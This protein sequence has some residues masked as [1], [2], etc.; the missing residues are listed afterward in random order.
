LKVFVLD[1]LDLFTAL[2]RVE[3][4]NHI[5]DHPEV[6]QAINAHPA[7]F[8]C[9][10]S[11]GLLRAAP[12]SQA[13]LRKIIFRFCMIKSDAQT[14]ILKQQLDA[15][16]MIRQLYLNC[17]STDWTRLRFPT[18]LTFIGIVKTLDDMDSFWEFVSIHPAVQMVSVRE[19]IRSLKSTNSYWLL[20]KL[21]P[22]A[23]RVLEEGLSCFISSIAIKKEKGTWWLKNVEI[24]VECG[25]GLVEGFCSKV[26]QLGSVFNGL[27]SLVLMATKWDRN[28]GPEEASIEVS[29]AASCMEYK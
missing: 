13:D 23:L 10:F 26:Q 8:T 14:S 29:S 22:E 12:V 16:I 9:K 5:W 11:Y 25:E 6:L 4:P 18:T 19:G 15:G 20:G 7:L 2:E 21:V 17:S 27:E 1:L 24:K 28:R 3:L